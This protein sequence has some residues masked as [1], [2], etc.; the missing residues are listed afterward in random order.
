M[1]ASAVYGADHD[2][3]DDAQNSS[4]AAAEET[5]QENGSMQTENS[6]T[7]KSVGEDDT[8]DSEKL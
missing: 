2:K 6:T 4:K 7:E 5:M 1:D 3:S 8:T